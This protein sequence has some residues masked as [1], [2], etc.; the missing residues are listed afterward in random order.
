MKRSRMEYR[1]DH[2]VASSALAVGRRSMVR[3]LF[4]LPVLHAT[5]HHH[6]YQIGKNL[7][8]NGLSQVNGVKRTVLCGTR[9]RSVGELWCR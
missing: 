1:R 4:H 3:L 8:R 7:W 9:I 6:V 2:V 5:N